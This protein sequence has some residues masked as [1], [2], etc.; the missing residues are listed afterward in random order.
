MHISSRSIVSRDRVASPSRDDR[1]PSRRAARAASLVASLAASLLGA[2]LPPDEPVAPD[3]AEVAA[4]LTSPS[5]QGTSYQGTSYQ[6]TSYQGTS[7]Q[8]TSYQGTSYQGASHGGASL[9]GGSVAGTALVAWKLVSGGMTPRWEERFPD[10]ICTW[11][12][13]RTIPYGCTSVD[14]K[15]SPSPLAGSTWRGTFRRPDDT[16]FEGTIRVD[17]VRADTSRA[18]HPLAQSGST[19]AR[20]HR[21]SCGHPDGCRVN[22]DL[23]LYDLTLVDTDG[24]V[25]SFCPAGEMAIALADTWTATGQR[26]ADASRF[27]FACTNG[28]IAKCTQWGY[29]PFGQA[30]WSNGVVKPLA[31]Y[32]QTCVRAAAADYCANGH[33]FTRDGTLIEIY[34]YRAELGEAGFIPRTLQAE[35]ALVLES[36]FDQQ[37]A[38]EVDYHRYHDLGSIQ[39]VCPQRF[40]LPTA[41]VPPYFDS[42]PST[43]LDLFQLPPYLAVDSTTACLHSER[44]L[45][46]ALHPKCSPCTM[47]VWQQSLALL[48][49]NC[50]DPRGAWDA[51]CI[52]AA[53]ATTGDP[54]IVCTED[55]RMAK[56]GECTTGTSLPL[57]A[58]AC[59]LAVCLDPALQSCCGLGSWTAACV[60]AANARCQGGREDP[61][62]LRGFCGQ[63][64]E[65]AP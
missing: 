44:T 58:S 45:G 47:K 50:T 52:A 54:A 39:T 33:S 46:E 12:L 20:D 36:R 51:T 9:S 31:G 2:C 7:Y 43:R 35:T 32:H 21:S 5:G 55:Q 27:T 24:Q 40:G 59:T 56:H 57:Y 15:L 3:E 17:A 8:G 11:N 38:L 28:T 30:G 60:S 14:L 23:W 26:T 19:C 63:E 65:N 34:D 6:G 49:S 48:P 29:R 1:E 37:G 41:P 62:K 13:L 18:M 53:L 10:K 22:C 64:L 42:K 61:L 16:T 4:A 25:V